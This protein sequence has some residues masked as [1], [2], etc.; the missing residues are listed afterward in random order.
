MATGVFAGKRYWRGIAVGIALVLLVAADTQARPGATI[1]PLE[2]FLAAQGTYCVEDGG[3]CMQIAPPVD[4]FLGWIDDDSGMAVSVD[5]A[6]LASAFLA[7]RGGPD[8][9]T[10]INGVIIEMPLPDGRADVRILLDTRNALTWVIDGVDYAHDPLLLGRRAPDVLAGKD[11]AL[12]DAFLQ[13]RFINTKPGAPLPDLVQ[14]A[15][16]PAPGQELRSMSFQAR[17]HGPLHA[18]SGAPEGTLGWTEIAQSSTFSTSAAGV[19]SE[20]ASTQ[21]IRLHVAGK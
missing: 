11:P 12:G 9:G 4:N 21:H 13:V 18:R 20:D 15:F 19:T 2:D 6:G 7:S 16:F 10:V 1:R 8:L 3:G 14:L 5:Y 17:A